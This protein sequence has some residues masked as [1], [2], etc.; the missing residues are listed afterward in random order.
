MELEAMKQVYTQLR[1][2][3]ELLRVT[4]ASE[5]PIFQIL[6]LAEAPDRKSGPSR[7]LISV[8]VILA[9]VFLSVFVAFA[10]NA[11]SNIR[12]DPQAMAKLRKTNV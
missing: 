7:G 3:M 8:I 12:K 4:M 11:I 1:V 10:L 2:Q 5:T 6:E 9:A